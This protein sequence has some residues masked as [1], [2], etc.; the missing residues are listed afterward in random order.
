MKHRIACAG[1]AA[2]ALSATISFARVPRPDEGCEITPIECD[3]IHYL[4]SGTWVPGDL[5]WEPNRLPT[6]PVGAEEVP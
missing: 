3:N 1:I 4:T 2:L 5:Q 6:A